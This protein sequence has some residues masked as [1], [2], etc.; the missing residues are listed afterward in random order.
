MGVAGGYLG[1]PRRPVS[2][3]ATRCPPLSDLFAAPQRGC[4]LFRKRCASTSEGT[5]SDEGLQRVLGGGR[6]CGQI[7]RPSKAFTV[8]QGDKVRTSFGPLGRTTSQP[9]CLTLS[10][11]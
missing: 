6:G 7:P 5:R 10:A 3:R 11:G 8:R 9:V 1:H 2:G 4:R